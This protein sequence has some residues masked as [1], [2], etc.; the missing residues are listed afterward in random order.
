MLAFRRLDIRRRQDLARRCCAERA[1]T[2]ERHSSRQARSRL[3][4]K[5]GLRLSHEFILQPRH[6]P[7]KSTRL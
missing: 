4:Q 6:S 5:L 7:D 1:G 3:P 2:P